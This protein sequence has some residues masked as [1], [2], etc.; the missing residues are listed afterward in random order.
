MAHGI[1]GHEGHAESRMV[2]LEGAGHL[3]HLTRGGVV[4]EA[5]ARFGRE[6]AA[7][8]PSDLTWRPRLVG[9]RVSEVVG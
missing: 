5:I 6:T 8:D 7:A 9:A 1:A 2:V 4:A 3:P